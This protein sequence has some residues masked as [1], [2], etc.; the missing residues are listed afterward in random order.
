MGS[1]PEPVTYAYVS[2][3]KVSKFG[4]RDVGKVQGHRGID[5]VLVLTAGWMDVK[6]FTRTRVEVRRD[7]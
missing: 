4:D 6:G 1:E 3:I 5:D 7:S 2:L